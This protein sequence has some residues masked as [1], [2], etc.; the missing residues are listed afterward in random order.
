MLIGKVKVD[1]ALKVW[2]SEGDFIA[3]RVPDERQG[4][5]SAISCEPGIKNIACCSPDQ[6]V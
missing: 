2:G 3:Y 1:Q 5:K 6:T 4:K